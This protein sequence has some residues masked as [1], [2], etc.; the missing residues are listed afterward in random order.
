MTNAVPEAVRAAI[1]VARA[2]SHETV[3]RWRRSEIWRATAARFSGEVDVA[4]EAARLLSD[5]GWAAA[6]LA[7]LV[8]A[9]AR[10]PLFEP[11]FRL[12]RDAV[13]TGAVI[14][15]CPVVSISASVFDAVALAAM[16]LPATIVFPGQVTV[17]RYHKSGGATVR[18]WET[19][20]LTP[21]FTAAGAAPC[22][23]LPSQRPPDSEV[24]RTDGRVQA[25]LIGE[26]VS[27]L[28]LLTATIRRGGDP[29]IREYRTHDGAFMRAAS[30]DDGASR[31]EMLL[32]FLRNAGRADA[33]G[34]FEAATRD[35]AFHLRWAAMREWLALD[36]RS[37]LPRL[38]EMAEGDPSGE[39]RDAAVRTLAP[40]RE[41][42]AASCLA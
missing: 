19:D 33:G 41:R 22:R 34:R 36:A 27:D 4:G 2:A 10:D 35:P 40:V 25:Q 7:P 23:S 14:F 9:L 39:V 28:V 21:G 12:N 13:R 38:A 8:E 1:P 6:F 18:R 30:A 31:T 17:T 3:L 29:L 5:A 16:P 24:L 32:T 37:A 15:D 20:P 26:A 42:I 11:P